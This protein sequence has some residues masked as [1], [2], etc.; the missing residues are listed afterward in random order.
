LP[1]TDRLLT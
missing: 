1:N